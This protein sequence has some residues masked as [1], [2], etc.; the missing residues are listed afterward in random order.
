MKAAHLIPY[1][2]GESNAA[3]L[4][5]V[6]LTEG[7]DALW[8]YKNGLY[9]HHRIEEALDA[10]QLVIVPDRDDNTILT[11]VL[12]DSSIA[13]AIVDDVQGGEVRFRDLGRL[14]FKTDARP[15]RRNLYI[16][17]LFTIF[18]R[19]RYGMLGHEHDFDKLRMADNS[20]W[21]SPGKWMRRSILQIIA[22]EVGDVFTGEMMKEII[23]LDEF[24][25]QESAEQE[26]RRVAE[27]RYGLEYGTPAVEDEEAQEEDD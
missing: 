1:C 23:G 3:Y 27:I 25:D 2:I 6:S 9:I 21:A 19:K 8:S 10:A 20:V 16:T 11:V 14:E 4:L 26:S 24:P 13:D 17:T 15:G 18:R 22:A 5:G 7:F 12:L